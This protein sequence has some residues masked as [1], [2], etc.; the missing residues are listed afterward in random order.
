V[1]KVFQWVFPTSE[2]AT[3]VRPLVSVIVVTYNQEAYISQCLESIVRQSISKDIEILVWDDAS[4][5]GT[6]AILREYSEKNSIPIK[7]FLQSEN[8][9]SKGIKI[10]QQ[11]LPHASGRYV[12][13]CDGDDYWLNPRKLELQV[14]FLEKNPAFSFTFHDATRVSESGGALAGGYF[15][16]FLRRDFG[17]EDLRLF[18]YEHMLYGVLLHRNGPIEFPPEFELV[19][20]TDN[21]FPEILSAFGAAKFLPEAGPLA[22]RQHRRGSFTGLDE[23][24]RFT[25]DVRTRLIISSYFLRKNPDRVMCLRFLQGYLLPMFSSWQGVISRRSGGAGGN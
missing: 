24:E 14:D 17:V 6:P 9:M 16:H 5:D 11:L 25:S 18:R 3:E 12:A 22:Y 2:R 15:P 21:F 7:L 4:S 10:R 8:Q 19:T 23:I 20:N 13:Y 1:S